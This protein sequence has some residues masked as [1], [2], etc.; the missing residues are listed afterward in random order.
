[1]QRGTDPASGRHAV[2][3][4]V[5][6]HVERL[7]AARDEGVQPP[8][9]LVDARSDARAHGER[10]LDAVDHERLPLH[11]LADAPGERHRAGARHVGQEQAERLA[12]VAGEDVL[13]AQQVAHDVG[14][15]PQDA[16]A[17]EVAVAVVHVLE[18]VHVDQD[19]RQR[20]VEAARA[21]E[22]LL[23]ELDER[24]PVEG[25]GEGVARGELLREVVGALLLHQ[26]ERHRRDED[27]RVGRH[28]AEGLDRGGR[29]EPAGGRVESDGAGRAQEEAG[30]ADREAREEQPPRAA[31]HRRSTRASARCGAAKHAAGGPRRPRSRAPGASRLAYLDEQALSRPRPTSPAPSYARRRCVPLHR[32]E[33]GSLGQAGHG[34]VAEAARVRRP[35]RRAAEGAALAAEGLSE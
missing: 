29:E 30:G 15:A 26:E 27:H 1:M 21:G 6:R 35:H 24:A 19:D 18:V 12:P 13:L 3:A 28:Q 32:G 2:A 16:V 33:L 5:L 9:A 10:D 23:G 34:A 20:R 17:D 22:L 25:A 11:R 8:G 14:E 4:A 31:A 7:V